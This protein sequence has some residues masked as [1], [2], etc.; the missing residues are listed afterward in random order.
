[1][2]AFEVYQPA[3]AQTWSARCTG[4][5]LDNVRHRRGR[6]GRGAG[7]L[8]PAGAVDELW[9]FFPD[10]WHKSRHHKRRLVSPG[11]ADLVA[12]RLQPGGAVAAGHRLGGLRA[13]H[14]RGAGRRIPAC[15]N[16]H[17]GG[18][19]PRWDAGR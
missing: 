5:A 15:E 10:P 11:F 2:L 9:T 3:V 16:L 8:L 18:W 13:R 19:A 1:M 4:P 17:P 6:R 14:A 7:H 12:A